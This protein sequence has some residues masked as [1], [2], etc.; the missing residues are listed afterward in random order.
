[1]SIIIRGGSHSHLWRYSRALALAHFTG[2]H[3]ES[4]PLW[5]GEAG[6]RLQRPV[7]EWAVFLFPHTW[8]DTMREANVFKPRPVCRGFKSWNSCK[9]TGRIS[10]ALHGFRHSIKNLRGS[11]KRCLHIILLN[12]LA[13]VQY[14]ICYRNTY[15]L[16]IVHVY[17][18]KKKTDIQNV[19]MSLNLAPG[20]HFLS[21]KFCL[22]LV[23]KQFE[24]SKGEKKWSRSNILS[25][26]IWLGL[27]R[28]YTRLSHT[29]MIDHPGMKEPHVFQHFNWPSGERRAT[30]RTL[31]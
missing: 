4:A 9:V 14:N 23:L 5:C 2:T 24:S 1:M 22:I 6:L 15:R 30:F 11:W 10:V 26:S 31:N 29:C 19:P 20:E 18:F 12:T 28:F 17:M 27:F 7:R 25:I 3:S 21:F 8:A 13:V 16:F